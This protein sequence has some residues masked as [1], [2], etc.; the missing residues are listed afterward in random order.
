[1]IRHIALDFL[2]SSLKEIPL[3][4]TPVKIGV[5]ERIPELLAIPSEVPI[6]N[7]A[8][9]WLGFLHFYCFYVERG[10]SGWS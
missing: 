6:V 2:H 10:G 8:L 7:Q 9:L 3:A 4:T 5:V 1:M